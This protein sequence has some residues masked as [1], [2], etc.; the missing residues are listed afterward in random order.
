MGKATKVSRAESKVLRKN[1]KKFQKVGVLEG[2]SL[3]AKA[4]AYNGTPVRARSE[5][6][7]IFTKREN[8]KV[9]NLK[10]MLLGEMCMH[11]KTKV[12]IQLKIK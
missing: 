4:S 6:N 9:L 10:K 1:T 12:W 2:K 5:E 3:I 7:E 8:R 11:F